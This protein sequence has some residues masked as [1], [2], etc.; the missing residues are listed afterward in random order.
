VA[1]VFNGGLNPATP[2]NPKH[3]FVIYMGI[4]AP[5]QFVF[6]PTVSHFR[7]LFVDILN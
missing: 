5:I 2:A 7:I 3:P 4:V 1:A 6:E